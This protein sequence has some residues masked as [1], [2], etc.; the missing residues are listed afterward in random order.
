LKKHLIIVVSSAVLSF[1]LSYYLVISNQ[2]EL[3]EYTIKIGLL[4]VFLGV[5]VTYVLYFIGIKLD[6]LYPWQTQTNNR[7]F[8]GFVLQMLVAFSII[9]GFIYLYSKSII[10]NEE[11]FTE[12]QE[13]VIKLSILLCI[14]LMVYSVI[15]FAFYSYYS[16]ATLQIE[17]VKQ[18]RKQIDLQLKALKSQLSPHFLFNSLN[19]ISSL[20]HTNTKKSELFIRKLA[21]MY[22]FTLNSYNSMLISLEEE[23][24]FV[25]SY[26]YLLET[27]FENKLKIEI[28]IS[29]DLHQTQ[30]PPLTIQMLI[31]NAVKHNTMDLENPL[32][33]SVY[34]EESHICVKNNITEEPSNRTSF[35]IGLKNINLRYLL[36]AKKGISISNGNV[37][38]VKLPIIR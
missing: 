14:L 31:E 16:F 38:L 9:F 29:K 32:H 33:V 3:Q 20:V 11:F 13:T 25:A 37:F 2:G 35:H 10:A 28:E 24:Q 4:S 15:Y 5:L 30:I 1:I 21:N 26:Q 17:S 12:Y 27:R 23:L 7:L 19:T 8:I 18:E 22:Q 36:L 34:V 6:K